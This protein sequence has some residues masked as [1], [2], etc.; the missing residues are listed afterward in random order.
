[1]SADRYTCPAA[2]APAAADGTRRLVLAASV[3]NDPA[4]GVVPPMAG[5]LASVLLKSV[6]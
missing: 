6:I 4:A 5:G 2:G 1:V 3:V